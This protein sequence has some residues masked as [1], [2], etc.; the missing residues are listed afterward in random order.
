MICLW[1]DAN[2]MLIIIFKK[3]LI[4][5]VKN[6]YVAV[7]LVKKLGGFAKRGNSK[8]SKFIT[9]IDKQAY[10]HAITR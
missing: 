10:F 5:N 6:F 7:S 3:Q 2:A 1:Y 4:F 9:T 8:N